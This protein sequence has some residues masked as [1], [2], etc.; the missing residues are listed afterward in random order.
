[1]VYQH[2]SKYQYFNDI[3]V[4]TGDEI[5]EKLIAETDF[6]D[7]VLF[8]KAFARHCSTLHFNGDSGLTPYKIL[9]LNVYIQRIS[10]T[11][12]NYAGKDSDDESAD[13]L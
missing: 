13:E 3:H 6:P 8:Q 5:K 1:M 4:I 10:P 11:F 2:A 7:S 12:Y 9:A